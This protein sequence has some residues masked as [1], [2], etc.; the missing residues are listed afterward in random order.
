MSPSRLAEISAVAFS[1]FVRSPGI[2]I[3]RFLAKDVVRHP[4]VQRIVEAYDSFEAEEEKQEGER[5]ENRQAER[6][7]RMAALNAQGSTPPFEN[8][9]SSDRPS[10]NGGAQ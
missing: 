9:S 6:E 5:R 1:R 2:S 8:S 4:L 10:G 7:A 3:T